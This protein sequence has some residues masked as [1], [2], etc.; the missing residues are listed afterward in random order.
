MSTKIGSA[1]ID[2][3]AQTEGAESNIGKLAGTAGRLVAGAG[4]VIGVGLA[5]ATKEAISMNANLETAEL[6]FTTLLG[7]AS[8]AEAHVASLF[9]FAAKTP[10]ETGPILTASRHLLIMGGE[11][12]A[13]EANLTLVGDAAAAVSQNMDEVAFWV[14]R[15][16][17]S[18]QAGRPFGEA[19][20]RLQEMGILSPEVRNEMEALQKAGAS[21]AEVWALMEERLGT[22][23][24]AMELQSESWKGLTSTII[25]NLGLLN[26]KALS[27]LFDVA[28]SAAGALADFL[29]SD[30][31]AQWAER[32]A[33]SLQ[34]VID[35]FAD[36]ESIPDAFLGA[37]EK[38]T[39]G[40]GIGAI[41]ERVGEIVQNVF[42]GIVDWLASGGF[43][44]IFTMIID[45]RER[46]LEAALKL[47]PALLDALLI[48]VPQLITMITTVVIPTLLNYITSSVPRLL[49]VALQLFT[50][51]V[52]ALVT[53]LPQLVSAL[54]NAL[55]V[56]VGTLLG[57]I[58]QLLDA[59]VTLFTT[60]LDAVIEIL[61]EL[62]DIL[63]G[64]VLPAVVET[65]L[66]MAPE[67]LRA[68]IE[69]L[70]TLAH[71]VLKILPELINTLVRV[72]LP[73]VLGTIIEMI[74]ELLE[75][76]LSLF[77]ELVAAVVEIVPELV[78][79]IIFEL[80]PAIVDAVIQLGPKLFNAGKEA[81]NRLWDGIKEVGRKI[82]NWVETNV[83]EKI[84][85][86]WPFS[87]AKAGPFAGRG[88][89]VYA[90]RNIMAL[91][92][93]GITQGAADVIAAAGLA[94][95]QLSAGL[96]VP[97]AP[98][99]VDGGAVS[100]QI[101][102]VNAGALLARQV[103]DELAWQRRTAGI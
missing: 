49:S 77:G 29:S 73:E 85:D 33:G 47:F 40:G 44:Q 76:G 94:T 11:A 46:L 91:L 5:F 97:Q 78:G 69:A 34:F 13:S 48:V 70:I 53:V 99:R 19:A 17:S 84:A 71:A 6:Q 74:P 60:L 95:S 24:G 32:I 21:N 102:T 54:G 3:D 23:S 56:I 88:N 89:P 87:P 8:E 4:A 96:T 100:V 22:F 79:V 2:V 61:P 10:F 62:I 64:E 25:D 52:Q 1:Y 58:P 42:T 28:K 43:E 57:M 65:V 7:S 26:A 51:L 81:L 59:A 93:D 38:M 86:L 90:G 41:F 16:Y 68:A 72:L 36:A 103:G 39:G 18:I 9:E 101:N 15:A 92:A 27:P 55:P 98:S 67:I 35:L 45:A 50:Q 82:A 80:I 14:G 12:L 75:A 83:V 37:F 20:A 63:F 31:A 30:L 66:N